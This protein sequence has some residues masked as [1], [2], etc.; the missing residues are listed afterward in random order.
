MATYSCA[1]DLFDAT[2]DAAIEMRRYK[3]QL[4]MLREGGNSQPMTRIIKGS[5][6]DPMLR[7]DS[8]IDLEA[9]WKQTVEVDE[10]V[11]ART[12]HVLYGRDNDGGVAS[13]L[14]MAYAD[15]MF[16]YYVALLPWKDVGDIV[17]YS[18]SR[19]KDIRNIV[20]DTVDGYGIDAVVSGRG[21]AEK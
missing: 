9:R 17:G 12:S 18:V 13:I 19:C 20:I 6:T 15:V 14:G 4:A 2:R 1:R 3:R 16:W 10:A 21:V 11:I 7:V 5:I 8:A